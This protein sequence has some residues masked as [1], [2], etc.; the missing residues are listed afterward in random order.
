M[1]RKLNSKKQGKQSG[2]KKKLSSLEFFLLIRSIPNDFASTYA[3]PIT[4]PPQALSR[5]STAIAVIIVAVVA[6]P[7]LI[8]I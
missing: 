3:T 5:A 1:S 8:V 6:F 2:A 4:P 7:W